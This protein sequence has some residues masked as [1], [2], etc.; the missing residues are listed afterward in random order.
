MPGLGAA[1]DDRK[2]A[3][4]LSYVR[5]AWGNV[6]TPVE[7][8][9]IADIRAATEGRTLPW[10]ADE[11]DNVDQALANNNAIRPAANGEIQLPASAA[12]VYG[13]TLKYRTTLDV[14]APWRRAEDVAE[15]TVDLGESASFEVHVLLAADD[16][17]AGD[18]FVLETDGS[19]AIGRV[20]STGDYNTFREVH[21][22]RIALKAGIN[23]LIL[24]PEG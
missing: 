16:D 24:R 15:W 22:G 2:L 19:H 21:A 10:R 9:F 23:H 18:K 6:S 17:S 11:L 3:G 7:P 14:L 8:E 5:R 12:T 13:E 4:L 1:F 20:I